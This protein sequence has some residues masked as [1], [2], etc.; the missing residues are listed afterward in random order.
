M[1]VTAD[2]YAGPAWD[3]LRAYRTARLTAAMGAHDLA[4][5]LYT[6]LDA[7]RYVTS[8]RPI[9]SMW[10]HGTRYAVLLTADGQV[11]FFVASGDMER[12]R[13]TMPWIAEPVP[14]PF[15]FA[16]G[17]PLIADAVRRCRVRG[18]IGVDLLPV[19]ALRHLERALP[20]VQFVDGLDAI[21]DARKIKHPL[22][23]AMLREAAEVADLGMQAALAAV[24]PGVTELE[25]SAAAATAMMLAGSEDIPYYPLVAS[26][27]H[28]VYGYRFPTTKRIRYGEMVRIDCG[29]AIVNGYNGDI[30][31]IAFAGTPTP[32]QRQV[33]RAVYQMLQA[34]VDRLRAGVLT[35]EVVEA[36]AQVARRW[37][38]EDH[39]YFGILGHGLGTDLH[40]AP[41]IGE[42]VTG[43]RP[44][45]RLEAGMVVALEPGILL[46]GVGG[47]HLEDV[48]VVTDGAPEV[49]TKTPF[50][51]EYL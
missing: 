34:G 2:W 48:A 22:E 37:G 44:P 18:R 40:E 11:T 9:Y 20:D 49:L 3:A 6:K 31:R 25:V 46:P 14:F 28:A 27:D 12:V 8:F 16:D 50:L 24:R 5:V 19:G 43:H 15:V 30:A 38:Y 29:A 51:A 10:F 45:Q 36:A 7:I 21:D 42:K 39:T 17:V 47:G 23:I 13:R 33:Y 35:T 4:A 41:T 32:E 26:G 1:A